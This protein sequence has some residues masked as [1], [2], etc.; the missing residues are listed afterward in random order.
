[1]TAD[2]KT[3]G[4]QTTAWE[5]GESGTELV[6]DG[7]GEGEVTF[8]V[9]NGPGPGPRRALPV[10]P[11]DGAAED[12][13]GV[14]EPQRAV[15]PGA[16]VVYPVTVKVPP[17]TAAGTYGLQ[18]VAY[19]ADTDPSESSVTSK[20]VGITVPPPP[21]KKGIPRWIFLVIAAV[22]LLIVGLGVF[23]LTRGGGGL[24]NQ[25]PPVIS[26]ELA[27]L[28]ALSA[29]PG[30]WSE[31]VDV[32]F[33]W[34]RCDRDGDDCSAIDGAVGPVFK[35]GATEAN[36]TVRVEVDGHQPGRRRGHGHRYQRAHGGGRRRQPRRCLVTGVF[37]L[38][39]SQAAAILGAD[40][41]V[42]VEQSTTA[43]R[44]RPVTRSSSTSG[45]APAPSSPGCDR[46]HRH[47]AEARHHRGLP[48]RVRA[49]AEGVLLGDD[50]IGP[51]SE[52]LARRVAEEVGVSLKVAIVVGVL[53]AV[54]FVGVLAPGGGEGEGDASTETENDGGVSAACSTGPA[55]R[56]SC[57][58]RTSR[59]PAPTRGTRLGGRL[60]DA[61]SSRSARWSS[62]R[63]WW[64]SLGL[65]GRR[66]GLVVVGWVWVVVGWVWVV[67][68]WVWVGVAARWS[69][70]S[71]RWSVVAGGRRR[72]V[73]PGQGLGDEER[74]Q[75]H[76][77]QGEQAD[78]DPAGLRSAAPP[79][80]AFGVAGGLVGRD[81]PAQHGRLVGG[82]VA[83]IAWVVAAAS[84][85]G[86]ACTG[87]PLRKTAPGRRAF[88]P[89]GNG[90]RGA[91]PSP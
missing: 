41:V 81:R 1:M 19:S 27:V 67:V 31:E 33:Q 79:P 44:S 89:S 70:W 17:G 58:W 29:S 66:L 73:V 39:S 64:S 5:I 74:G 84:I 30:D 45:P 88:R 78:H 18:G 21:P 4:E 28:V 42:E 48:A 7:D 51:I 20:R 49:G 3:L 61:R 43:G 23:F 63:V 69:G 71:V 56:R 59:R 77:D 32:E 46:H 36:L 11:L 76:R 50:P 80:R 83:G 38:P 14:D 60:A 13:F 6:L 55:T 12:W 16:S 65:G 24:A 40:F 10:T 87:W 72:G 22:L 15:A 8:T 34:Q 9:T 52:D 37:G 68:G 90:C 26:G 25:E 75:P 62:V 86:V 85:S 57:P 47:R 54:L 2:E 91:W 53:V 35:P 82:A